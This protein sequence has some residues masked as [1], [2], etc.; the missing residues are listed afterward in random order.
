MAT[1][2][3]FAR[4]AV[5][6]YKAAERE[7]KRNAREAA[8]LYKEE[9]KQQE[10]SNASQTVRKYENYIDSIMSIHKNATDKIDWNLV[11][12]DPEP[13]KPVKS[14]SN[15][16]SAKLERTNFTPSFFEKIFGYK[17]K[18]AGLDNAIN[19]GVKKDENDFIAAT[20]L[21][22]DWEQGR[23]IAK[24][25]LDKN[26]KGYADAINFFQPFSD[27]SDMGSKISLSFDKDIVEVEL[28][29]NNSEVIPNYVVS[30]TK[31]GKLSTKDMPKGKFNEMYQDYVC[32]ALLRVAR[33]TLAYL[34]IKSVTVHAM[35]ELINPTSGHTES[36][37]I[38]S[39]TLNPEQ[40]DGLNFETL[41]PSDSMAN[42]QHNM[43]FNKTKGFTP[44]EKIEFK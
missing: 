42:F 6:A 2:N 31:T 14:D 26:T 4:G 20:E 27:I 13:P 5:R 18:L 34:P 22:Q 33:E 21:Y 40:I 37:P 3:Q 44:V 15:E 32:G 1:A 29:V 12:N 8:K 19:E 43:K 38:V 23:K 10:I 9:Q 39:A 36:T 11:L 28:A 7:Q 24:E 30:Q 41:D 17:K 25:V 35:S 16:K